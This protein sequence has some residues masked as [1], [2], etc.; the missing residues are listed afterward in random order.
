MAEL[1]KEDI[2]EDHDSEGARCLPRLPLSPFL[3]SAPPDARRSFLRPDQ[4][5]TSAARSGAEGVFS[6]DPAAGSEATEDGVEHPLPRSE[7]GGRL[8]LQGCQ[9]ASYP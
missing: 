5:P 6:G 1:V 3:C 7:H 4:L 2:G 9:A 8:G